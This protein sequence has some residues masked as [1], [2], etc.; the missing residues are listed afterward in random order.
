[1]D[2]IGN[3]QRCSA[4]RTTG[5]YLLLD[6]FIMATAIPRKHH[7]LISHSRIHKPSALYKVP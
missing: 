3:E 7:Q 4:D 1:M 6:C 5:T 2:V